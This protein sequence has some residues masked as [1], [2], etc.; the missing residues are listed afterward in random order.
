[1]KKKYSKK[2]FEEAMRTLL[3]ARKEAKR[4]G[5]TENLINIGITFYEF[6]LKLPVDDDEK[7][8]N[9]IGFIHVEEDK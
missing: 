2:A 8:K 6:G 4:S 3:M 1:M 5:D 9:K 7:V